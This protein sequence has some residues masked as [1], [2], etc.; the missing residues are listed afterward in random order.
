[1]VRLLG[2]FSLSLLIALPNKADAETTAMDLITVTSGEGGVVSSPVDPGA[3][4]VRPPF[5]IEWTGTGVVAIDGKPFRVSQR[6]PA[7]DESHFQV[8]SFDYLDSSGVWRQA[9]RGGG[10]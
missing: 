3:A 5:G 2:F 10:I 8:A 7:L 9:E 1:M 4:L 6:G